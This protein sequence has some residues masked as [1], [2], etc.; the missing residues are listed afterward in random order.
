MYSINL[1]IRCIYKWLCIVGPVGEGLNL[2][3][4]IKLKYNFFDLT[5]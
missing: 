5:F 3:E 1:S 2:F 4:L